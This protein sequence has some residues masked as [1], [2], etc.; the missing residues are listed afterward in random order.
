MKIK[1]YYPS[2]FLSLIILFVTACG[3]NETEGNIHG[4]EATEEE[5]QTRIEG[6]LPPL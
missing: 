1:H 4:N 3:N 5:F 6:D 2:L